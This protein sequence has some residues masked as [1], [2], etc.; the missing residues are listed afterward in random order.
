MP[1]ELLTDPP[2]IACEFGDGRQQAVAARRGR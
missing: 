1:A 2:G